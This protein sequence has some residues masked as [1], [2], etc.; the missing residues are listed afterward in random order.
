MSI[1]TVSLSDLSV[2]VLLSTP[3][4]TF[5]QYPCGFPRPWL[6]QRVRDEPSPEEERTIERHDPVVLRLPRRRAPRRA[7]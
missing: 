7:S 6:F 3:Y 2:G 4:L 1:V 5:A